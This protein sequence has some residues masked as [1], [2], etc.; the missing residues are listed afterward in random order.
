ME[1]LQKAVVLTCLI[2]ALRDKGNW[3]GETHIQK[4]TYFLQ[5]L[6]DVPLGFQFVLYRHGPFSFDLR[7]EMTGLRADALLA[8]EPQMPPYGPRYSLTERAVYVQGLFPRTLKQYRYRINFLVDR[9]GA[10]GVNALEQL[11]TGYYV[12]RKLEGASVNQ[13]AEELIRLKPHVPDKEAWAAI[14]EVD[15]TIEQV[16]ALDL[17]GLATPHP[18]HAIA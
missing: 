13:R 18:A 5:E 6:L 1:R 9:L 14:L 11:A 3:A 16:K 7:D 15:A 8:I 17:V 10:N 4:A 2:E 12:T